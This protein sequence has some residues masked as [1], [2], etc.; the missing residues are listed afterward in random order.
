MPLKQ[1]ANKKCVVR[2]TPAATTQPGA[3]NIIWPLGGTPGLPPTSPAYYDFSIDQTLFTEAKR[4]SVDGE[5]ILL[6]KIANKT[7]GDAASGG[8]VADFKCQVPSQLVTQWTVRGTYEVN[9]TATRTTCEGKAVM[10]QGDSTVTACTC[11][12]QYIVGST[13]IACSGSCKIEIV[14]AG[15][16]RVN[17]Q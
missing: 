13:T 6:E 1:V 11:S 12:G 4:T 16:S 17:A 2:V 10:R 15:Q 7:K 8:T 14:N 5:K 9:A 3:P